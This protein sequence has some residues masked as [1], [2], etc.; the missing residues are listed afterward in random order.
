MTPLTALMNSVRLF[1]AL[2]LCGVCPDHRC[3][4]CGSQSIASQAFPWNCRR[5]NVLKRIHPDPEHRNRNVFLC[6]LETTVWAEETFNPL[7][8]DLRRLQASPANAGGF[9]V[10]P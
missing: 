8:A 1:Y 6:A 7:K 9:P 10:P 5:K 4:V 3:S 2:T